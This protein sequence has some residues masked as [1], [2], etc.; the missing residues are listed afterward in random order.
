MISN[1][2]VGEAFGVNGFFPVGIGFLQQLFQV[3]RLL[4]EVEFGPFDP[5]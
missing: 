5:G 4:V 2:P 1:S 3:H